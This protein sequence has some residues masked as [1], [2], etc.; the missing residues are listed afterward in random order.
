MT[1]TILEGAK[2]ILSWNPSIFDVEQT[3]IHLQYYPSR[4]IIDVFNQ[5]IYSNRDIGESVINFDKERILKGELRALYQR[6]Y[7]QKLFKQLLEED[8][9]LKHLSTLI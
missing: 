5:K 6:S 1:K 9:E 3:L 7:A 4:D 8:P 2:Q